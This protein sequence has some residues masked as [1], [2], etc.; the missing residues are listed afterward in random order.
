MLIQ[1]GAGDRRGGVLDEGNEHRPEG[2]LIT[3]S[4]VRPESQVLY[5]VRYLGPNISIQEAG[6]V[7]SRA[8]CLTTWKCSSRATTK[9]GSFSSSLWSVLKTSSAL[10]SCPLA[11]ARGRCQLESGSKKDRIPTSHLGD[12]GMTKSMAAMPIAGSAANTCG[13]RQF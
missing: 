11:V 8:I 1:S 9:W 7:L 6:R 3:M 4:W 10:A 2:S 5:L 12:S 13:T